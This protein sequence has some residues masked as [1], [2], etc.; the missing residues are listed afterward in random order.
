MSLTLGLLLALLVALAAAGLG[1]VLGQRAARRK[2]RQPLPRDW[3]LMARPVLNG[4]ERRAMRLLREALP[5]YTV[6]AK[7]PLVRLCQPRDPQRGRYWYDLLGPLHVSFVVCSPNG[8]VLAA[9]DLQ[10]ERGMS[11]RAAI[12]KQSVMDACRIRYLSCRAENL[13][14]AS[15]L[16]LLVPVQGLAPRPAPLT[17]PA[18]QQARSSLSDT[19]RSRRE[20]RS[21]LWG[22]SAFA[23]DS[24][25]A[26]DSRMDSSP[27]SDFAPSGFAPS[28]YEPSSFGPSGFGP[29]TTDP[30]DAAAAEAALAAVRQRRHRR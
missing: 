11:A 6:L 10:P 14:P 13:P 15:E 28:T 20:Q 29:S 8:R 30:R 5:Q 25:F 26:P 3:D 12:I 24:F 16:Q 7:L 2:T 1:H 23:L 22:D 4:D 9:V 27:P 19:V 18:F 21:Q 17:P